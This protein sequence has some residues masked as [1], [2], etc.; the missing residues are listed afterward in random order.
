M[1][2]LFFKKNAALKALYTSSLTAKRHK[3]IMA[4]SV[5]KNVTQ[6]RLND[7]YPLSAVC[8]DTFIVL[9][10]FSTEMNDKRWSFPFPVW[11]LNSTNN[12]KKKRRRTSH[13][14]N[15]HSNESK[16]FGFVV[17]QKTL[18]MTRSPMCDILPL[19]KTYWN[20]LV[21]CI[22]VLRHAAQYLL[23]ACLRICK[24]WGFL[25][26]LSYIDT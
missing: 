9:H 8:P 16:I 24:H 17:M 5:D 18:A 23:V 26:F 10:F 14:W 11:K 19:K 1:R 13:M 7:Q 4:R 22:L 6:L 21:T 25:R 3:S 2:F 12:N 20:V 15:G